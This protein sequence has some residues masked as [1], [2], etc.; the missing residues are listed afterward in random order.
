MAFYSPLR[1]PGGKGKLA[2]YISNVI[3]SNNFNSYCYVEPYAGGAGVAI[4]L[5]LTNTVPKIIINDLDFHIFAFWHSVLHETVALCKLI[6]NISVDM[7]SWHA[8]KAIHD[9]YEKHDILSVG[10]STFFLNRTNRSG[11][12]SGGVIDGKSQSGK[13]KIDARFN[14]KDLISRIQAIGHRR[15]SIK[16][17]NEDASFL[18]QSLKKSKKDKYIFYFD[19]PYFK[20][21]YLLYQNSYDG[22]DHWNMA[23]QIKGLS[24]PWL[25]TYDRRPEIEEMYDGVSSCEFDIS[26]SAHLARVRGL[27]VMFYGNLELPCTPYARMT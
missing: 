15:D 5:L 12:L 6:E 21:G 11:I 3:N 25:V 9:G 2:P 27:E 16:I 24:C 17:F 23:I 22:K 13:Y 8:Q 20:K 18:I 26:Y 14:K 10:F 19:P 4:Q 7:E 1:Y